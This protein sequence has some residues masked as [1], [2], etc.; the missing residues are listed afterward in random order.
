MMASIH[1]RSKD[2]LHLLSL[3]G[4]QHAI[5]QAHQLLP[6]QGSTINHDDCLAKRIPKQTMDQLLL[7][8]PPHSHVLQLHLA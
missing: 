8:I 5:R 6:I 3:L 7:P 2:G 4:H 1:Y